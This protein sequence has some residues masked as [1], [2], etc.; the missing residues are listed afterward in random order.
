MI[1]LEKFVVVVPIF[2]SFSTLFEVGWGLRKGKEVA[3][4]EK[5]S[6]FLLGDSHIKYRKECFPEGREKCSWSAK[7]CSLSKLL[8][9]VKSPG[10]WPAC[11]KVC[12][13]IVF[14]VS[15]LGVF[16]IFFPPPVHL[17]VLHFESYLL[18]AFNFKI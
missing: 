16:L 12:V 4:F 2:S 8:K 11:V 7:V 17:L 3:K 10:K 14:T 1:L 9:E 5:F 6:H 15:V 18:Q 13:L